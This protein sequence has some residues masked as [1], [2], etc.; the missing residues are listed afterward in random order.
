MA[1]SSVQF[2][3]RFPLLVIPN[4]LRIGPILVLFLPL[5][6]NTTF[7]LVTVIWIPSEIFTILLISFPHL[8]F[9]EESIVSSHRRIRWIYSIGPESMYIQH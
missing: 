4:I 5:H 6:S 2:L 8:P 9:N 1:Y 3:R 7:H